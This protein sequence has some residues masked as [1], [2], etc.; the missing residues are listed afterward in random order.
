MF[1]GI[2]MK[3]NAHRLFIYKHKDRHAQESITT[4]K[5]WR[6]DFGYSFNGV[7]DGCLAGCIWS[8]WILKF[9]DWVIYG[10]F[11]NWGS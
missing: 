6:L 2:V 11:V 8:F 9:N 5:F 10:D 1:Y 7:L 4:Y 3:M